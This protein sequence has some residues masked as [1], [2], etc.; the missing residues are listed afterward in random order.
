[1]YETMPNIS[2]HYAK[3]DWEGHDGEQR[4]I[5]FLIGWN[6]IHIYQVLRC[7]TNIISLEEGRRLPSIKV[8]RLLIHLEGVLLK[9][10]ITCHRH[11]INIALGNPN[12][13]NFHPRRKPSPKSIE[14]LVDHL[15]LLH[16]NSLLDD[17]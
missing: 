17:L 4:R 6:T 7:P 10:L 5:D 9:D 1:M 13:S 8:I 2:E 15:F 12:V 16:N 3:L 11:F 14:D